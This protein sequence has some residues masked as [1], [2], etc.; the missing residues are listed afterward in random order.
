MTIICYT[1]FFICLNIVLSINLNKLFPHNIYVLKTLERRRVYHIYAKFCMNSA[2]KSMKKPFIITI[3]VILLITLYFVLHF[4]HVQDSALGTLGPKGKIVFSLGPVVGGSSAFTQTNYLGGASGNVIEYIVTA[5]IEA[6]TD[7]FAC[8]NGL[9]ISHIFKPLF[10]F[11]LIYF[12]IGIMAYFDQKLYHQDAAGKEFGDAE[13]YSDFKAYNE[14]YVDPY[15]EENRAAGYTENNILLASNLKL[16]MNT[17]KTQLNLHT[18]I[19]GGSGAGKTFKQIKPN[20]AQMNSSMVITDPSGEIMRSMGNMFMNNGYNMKIF[21]TSDMKHSSCYNPMDYIYD[22]NG[23][24]DQVK[25]SV[26]VSTFLANAD[27]MSKGKKGGDPFWDK[28]AKAW[29][30]FA[31]LFIAR[32]LPIEQR[33]MA[34]ALKLAQ[35]GK[36]DEESSSSKTILDKIV[37]AKRIIDPKAKCFS[38][39]DTFNLAPAKT[40]NSIL[41]SIAVDLN[42]FSIDEVRNMTSTSYLCKRDKHGLI[43][44]FITDNEGNPIRDNNNLDLGKMGD[45]KT[46]LFVNIPQANGAFNFLVSMMYSQMFDILYSQSEHVC[47]NRFHIYD[48]FGGV[49]SSEYLTEDMAKHYQELYSNATVKEE[50]DKSMGRVR[51]YVFNPDATKEETLLEKSHLPRGNRGY[52]KEV[53]TYDVGEKLINRYKEAYVKKGALRLPIHVRFYLDEF[54]NIGE[55]NDF[56]KML[57][58]MR[59]YEMSCAIVIQSLGQLEEKY[60]KTWEIAVGNCDEIVF[61]GSSELK[62][63]KYISD[64]LGTAT[65]RTYD[66]GQSKSSNSGSASTNFKK[67]ARKLL[68][69]EE[70]S[71]V[72]DEAIVFIRG[73]QPFK[74]PK[75]S[76]ADSPNFKQTGGYDESLAVTNEYLDEY[77]TC[78]CKDMAGDDMATNNEIRSQNILHGKGPNGQKTTVRQTELKDRASTAKAIGA[79]VNAVDDEAKFARSADPRDKEYTADFEAS[80]IPKNAYMAQLSSA[81]NASATS[82]GSSLPF[83]D[84]ATKAASASGSSTISA[85][86]RADAPNSDDSYLLQ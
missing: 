35:Q 70:V 55:I 27:S 47:P 60:D 26:L 65:I 18:L 86:S 25:V 8:F 7:P 9:V 6:V 37:E 59:K 5:A 78:T 76:F 2:K 3:A 21:S 51:Y 42:N 81:N 67:Q 24:L 29:M 44:E 58:T 75:L 43:K 12:L 80:Q 85:P 49:L 34:S 30:T 69:P 13:W 62:T 56:Q 11:Y 10:I 66:T 45:E 68:T 50:N 46:V 61:L 28:S 15:T 84:N 1:V 79:P 39:Y 52:L 20:V 38:S 72:Q 71:R 22:E 32:F 53:H 41:I 73:L 77:F 4:V 48:K 17:H 36:A 74:I 82:S 40:R 23:E 57:S 63:D 83:P 16:S 33:N 19:I 31:I 64:K 54:A 14:K